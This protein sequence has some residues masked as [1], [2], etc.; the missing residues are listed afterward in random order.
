MTDVYIVVNDN[1]QYDDSGYSQ[2]GPD[3]KLVH[4]TEE[5]AYDEAW[6][7]V[8]GMLNNY[9]KPDHWNSAKI[10]KEADLPEGTDHYELNEKDAKEYVE[11]ARK[12]YELPFF[13]IVR[14]QMAE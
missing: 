13:K 6:S 1:Y 5:A 2:Y 10:V 12:L 9:R 7:L 8:A 3:G 11:A 4:K 14:M